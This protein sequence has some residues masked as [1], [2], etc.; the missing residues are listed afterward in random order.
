MQKELKKYI[1]DHKKYF[2]KN[3]NLNFKKVS[4]KEIEKLKKEINKNKYEIGEEFYEFLK[5]VNGLDYYGLM[6]FGTKDYCFYKDLEIFG[7]IEYNE[8]L[9]EDDLNDKNI[10]FGVMGD[11]LFAYTKDKKWIVMDIFSGD[12]M[13]EYDTFSSLLI[14]Q[15]EILS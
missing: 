2:S 15:M 3:Y 10:Y 7:I 11:D 5:E 9:K 14:K 12:A 1:E 6:I 4:Q 8:I 13:E